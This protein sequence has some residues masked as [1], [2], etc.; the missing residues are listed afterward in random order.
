MAAAALLLSGC[1]TDTYMG[2]PL[3][4]GATPPELQHLANLARTGDKR[5]QLDLGIRY[6]EGRGLPVDLKRAEKLY[7]AAAIDGGGTIYTYLPPVGGEAKGRVIPLNIGSKI[8]GLQ[9]AKHRLQR[10][11]NRKDVGWNSSK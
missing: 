4:P 3:V 2:I 8:Y 9:E 1:A 6:E 7:R 10:L 5:A 11:S